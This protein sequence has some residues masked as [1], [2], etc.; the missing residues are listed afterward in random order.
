MFIFTSVSYVFLLLISILLFS[1]KTFSISRKGGLVVV[2]PSAFI[3]QKKSIS[4]LFL[5]D[6]F[7]G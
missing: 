3:C 6:S 4:S 2:T 5:K 7:A 1:L